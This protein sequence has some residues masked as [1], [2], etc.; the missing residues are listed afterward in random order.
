[1]N[2]AVHT[3]QATG[4]CRNCGKAI[5]PQCTR[6][7]QGA[8]YC[9]PCLGNS[10]GPHAL[11]QAAKQGTNPGLAAV[12]GLIPG[13]GAVYNGQYVKALI[14]VLIF[15]GL[16]AMESTDLPGGFGALFGVAIG[17]FYLLHADRSLPHREAHL[18]GRTPE[19]V[20][21]TDI[22]STQRNRSARWS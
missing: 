12:L 5:C 16:I 3:E 14:H 17:C 10:P 2:C 11:N 20:G 15:G 8:L 21:I 1:M 22:G 13:L 4:Y 18:L 7:V 9:E 19:P 6:E